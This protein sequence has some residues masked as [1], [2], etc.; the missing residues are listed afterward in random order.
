MKKQVESITTEE[1]LW[2]EGRKQGHEMIE[3]GDGSAADKKRKKA[4]FDVRIIEARER[5]DL[6]PANKN[7]NHA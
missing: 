1:A 5:D 7:G 2:E 6:D 4:A 3:A